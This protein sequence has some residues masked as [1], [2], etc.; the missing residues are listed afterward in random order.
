VLQVLSILLRGICSTACP[1]HAHC[2][3]DASPLSAHC[4]SYAV[5]LGVPRPSI[6]PQFNNS[7]PFLPLPAVI[8]PRLLLP[9]APPSCSSSSPLNFV[10]S[11]LKAS[12]SNHLGYF[13]P[14][15]SRQFDCSVSP[16]TRPPP[17]LGNVGFQPTAQRAQRDPLKSDSKTS[18]CA[19]P[20]PR[21]ALPAA[22]H[23]TPA[24]PFP[25]CPRITCFSVRRA[26]QLPDET[27]PATRDRSH[28]A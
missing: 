9:L 6:C 24:P 2:L 11:F 26:R 19:S 4:S 7:S 5:P 25:I 1:L 8:N 28:S 27:R 22:H 23:R 15:T 12:T 13:F 17:A 3:P 18:P 16:T 14:H 10:T 21:L 20:L